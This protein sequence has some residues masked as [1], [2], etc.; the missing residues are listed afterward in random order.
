MYKQSPDPLPLSMKSAILFGASGLVGSSLLTQLLDNPA[1]DKVIIVVRKPLPVQHQKLKTVIGDYA[2][3][4]D[5]KQQLCAD[6]V[7]ISLGTTK[8]KTPDQNEYYQIDH[9]YPVLAASIAKINGARSVLLVSAIDANANSKIFYVRTKGQVEADIIALG[10]E[11]TYTFHP[12]LLVGDR[13]ESRP[14]EKFFIGLFSILN[15]LLG[16]SWKRYHSIHVKDLA[17]AMIN[18]ANDPTVTVKRYQWQDMSGW[19]R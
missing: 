18:V 13:K 4:P 5:L 3:L 6:E 7:F 10:F 8:K 16:G 12:S 2:A 9:D 15:P 14:M 17:T 1:Y 11:H 19:V